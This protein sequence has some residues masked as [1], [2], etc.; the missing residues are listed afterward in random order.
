MSEERFRVLFEY[1]S[2][3]HL[4]LDLLNVD[5][6]PPI[7]LMALW[8]LSSDYYKFPWPLFLDVGRTLSWS[9]ALHDLVA[10]AW[11]TAL[12]LPLAPQLVEEIFGW[13]KTV[14]L[15]RKTRHRGRARVSWMFIFGLAAY[16][17][18]RIRNLAEAAG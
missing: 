12:L 3:A 14:G 8:P 5:T 6:H 10:V 9:T 2:D 4:L 17:L 16:N 13:L 15:L 18:V 1:S 7:G 11:E